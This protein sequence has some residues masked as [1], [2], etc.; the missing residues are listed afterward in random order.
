MR[1]PRSFYSRFRW[2]LRHAYRCLVLVYDGGPRVLGSMW[3]RPEALH[4]PY[5]GMVL[6]D[7]VGRRLRFTA[8]LALAGKDSVPLLDPQYCLGTAGWISKY[9]RFVRAL[10]RI[11]VRREGFHR[12]P[13]FGDVSARGCDPRSA[14]PPR[15][16]YF[17][18]RLRCRMRAGRSYIAFN[19]ESPSG[20]HKQFWAINPTEY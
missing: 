1:L 10:C 13:Y 5:I 14:A 20:G 19:V 15:I 9:S 18:P 7:L 11:E 6:D 12:H 16:D 4:R 8:P 3:D 2:A 17:G